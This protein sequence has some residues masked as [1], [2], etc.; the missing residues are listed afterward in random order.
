VGVLLPRK[1]VGVT[2]VDLGTL[3]EVTLDPD[4]TK[5]DPLVR[6][7]VALEGTLSVRRGNMDCVGRGVRNA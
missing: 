1:D 3:G 7:E 6:P 2:E 4:R 5:V